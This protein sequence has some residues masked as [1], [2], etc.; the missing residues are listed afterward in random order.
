MVHNGIEYGDMQLIA[1]SY[2]LLKNVGRLSNDQLADVFEE[3]NKGQLESFLIE[4]TGIIFRQTEPENKDEYTVDK[5]SAVDGVDNGGHRCA[6]SFCR[7]HVVLDGFHMLGLGQDRYE[8]NRPLDCTGSCRKIGMN[9][10]NRNKTH[11]QLR[12]TFAFA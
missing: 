8:R 2:D 1:E 6:N 5:A 10:K 9:E 3:W 12:I 4:I 7:V 11:V